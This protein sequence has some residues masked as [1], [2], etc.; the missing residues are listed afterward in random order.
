MSL[1]Y[2]DAGVDIDEGNKLIEM[3]KPIVKKT[4]RPEVLTDIGSF[5]AMF[6]LNNS[7]NYKRPVLVSSADGVGTKL[8]VAFMMD[9]HDTIGID[10]VA[11]NVNDIIV[12]GAE[13]L[14]F[15]D[16]LAT[17]K[18][19]ANVACEVIKGIA[20]GCMEAECSLIGGETAEM[21]S[22]YNE[23]DYDLAG[24]AVGMVDND[25]IIDGSNIKI[26][27]KII[28]LSSSGLHSNGYSLA[29]KVFFDKLK[30][31]VED[32]IPELNKTVGELLLEPTVIYVKTIKNIMKTFKINGIVHITGGGFYENINRVLPKSCVADL[33]FG[34]YDIPPLF[35]YIKDSGKITSNE[36]LRTFNCG[37]GMVLIVRSEDAEDIVH[38]ADVFGNKAFII[39]DVIK[40]KPSHSDPVVIHKAS[41]K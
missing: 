26:G 16:Y 33:D 3:I 12:Q 23:G 8:R 38:R 24:F 40:K 32:T 10:L 6:S 36:M 27:D 37:I 2:K 31:T 5:G 28:G 29:R 39:G 30:K 1:S 34:D 14:F 11:M 25:D 9:K 41:W 18:L 22:F 7:S 21:P 20:K 35:K 13:P 17:S 19:D 4:F 15:L